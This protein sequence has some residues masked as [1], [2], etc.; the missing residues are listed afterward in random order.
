MGIWLRTDEREEVLKT[1]SACRDFLKKVHED[2]SYWKWVFISLHN[3]I[4]GA[5]VVALRRTD[6]FGPIREDIEKKWYKKYRETGESGPINEK[7]MN[8]PD[9]YEKIKREETL[10]WTSVTAYKPP[11][12]QDWAMKKLNSIRNEFIHFTPKGWSLELSGAPGICFSVLDIPKFLVANCSAF[13]IY[14][15][16]SSEDF[17]M[18]LSQIEE[19]LNV[20]ERKYAEQGAGANGD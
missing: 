1:L 13:G 15:G 16:H 12:N 10:Q 11:S 20:L 5:M 3:A 18:E 2:K 9:L 8:F 19:S 14:P 6:G 7:L 4:Q 17:S